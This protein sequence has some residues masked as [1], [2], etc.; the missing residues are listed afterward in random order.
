MSTP[1]FKEWK[2]KKEDMQRWKFFGWAKHA[3]GTL[4]LL[5]LVVYAAHL[6]GW[7]TLPIGSKLRF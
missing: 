3:A 7:I 6:N 1:E 5:G 2:R 4:L